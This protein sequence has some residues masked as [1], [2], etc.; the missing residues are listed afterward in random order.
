MKAVKEIRDERT[1][2]YSFWED[3]KY[4]ETVNGVDAIVVKSEKV[5]EIT[6]EEMTKRIADL[7]KEKVEKASKLALEKSKLKMLTDLIAKK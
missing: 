2:V 6:L 1:D 4:I 5:E 7:E 3:K